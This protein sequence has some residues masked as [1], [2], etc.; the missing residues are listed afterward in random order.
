[1]LPLHRRAWELH[2][3]HAARYVLID[4]ASPV[5]LAASFRSNQLNVYR[6]Q[7]DIPWNIAGARNLSFHVASTDWVLCADIDHVI[8][9]EALE[10]I[11]ALDLTDSNTAYT[12]SRRRRDGYMGC[13][14][15]I[16]I[17]MNRQRFFEMGGYDEDYCGHYGKEETFFHHCLKYHRVKIV[18]CAGIV[19]DWHPDLG[20]TGTLSR[21]VACNKNIFERKMEEL[22]NGSYRPGPRLRFSW[23]PRP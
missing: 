19:L 17:L 12:F 21:D 9:A 10:Q 16:N 18:K 14:A 20:R 13:D 7:E 11:L 3:P 22:R 4:D 15:I 23:A 8:T 6:V 5:P 1:M 2:P